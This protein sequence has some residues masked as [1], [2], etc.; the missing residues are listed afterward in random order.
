MSSDM[1][2]MPKRTL[3]GLV[4]G[5]AVLLALFRIPPAGGCILLSALAC[6]GALEFY[7]LLDHAGIPS[8]RRV[9]A[10]C[11]ML[12]VAA[13]WWRLAGTDSSR[14]NVF[15]IEQFVLFGTTIAVLVRL[16]PQKHN[17]QPMATVACTLLGFLYVPVLL[18]YITKLAFTWRPAAEPAHWTQPAYPLVF[19]LIFVVKM[20]DI[21]AYF[22][23]SRFGRHK[24]IPRISPGKTVEGFIGGLVIGT[25]GGAL[26]YMAAP[27]WFEFVGVRMNVFHSVLLGFALSLIGTVGDLTESLLKR[28]SGA[29]DSG[30]FIPGMGGLLDV[31]DSLLFAAPA[32]YIYVRI[33]LAP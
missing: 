31:I 3:T 16:F 27:A 18:N 25:V 15:E 22:T 26:F 5:A 7:R 10:A 12:L 4:M 29:K 13:T 17:Q 23:G 1:R 28:S 30:R 21:G 33:F 14:F 2:E 24:L 6:M 8:F 32:M 20:T 19:F 11:G 9:G